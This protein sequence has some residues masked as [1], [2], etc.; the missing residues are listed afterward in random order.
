MAVSA[1]GYNVLEVFNGRDRRYA[2]HPNPIAGD[3]VVRFVCISGGVNQ[4]ERLLCFRSVEHLRRVFASRIY[5]DRSSD[6]KCL[7][8]NENSARDRSQQVPR[9]AFEVPSEVADRPTPRVVRRRRRPPC[10][11]S[12]TRSG[13]EPTAV[14][15]LWATRSTRSASHDLREK[16]RRRPEEMEIPQIRCEMR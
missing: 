4:I 16:S 13:R 12:T 2:S 5:Y 15:K 7:T 8:Y 14:S 10:A 1:F 9:P 6:P 11:R 3:A